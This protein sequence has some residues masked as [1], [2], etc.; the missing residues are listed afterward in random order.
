M[1][2]YPV[3]DGLETAGLTLWSATVADY[4]LTPA[5]IRILEDAAREADLIAH[6]DREW[7]R[8]GR[9]LISLGSAKQEVA[10]PILMELRQHRGT[11][12]QLLNNL[13]LPSATDSPPSVI[14]LVDELGNPR[15]MTRSESG[16]YAASVRY[17]RAG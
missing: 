7:I 13:R 10:H 6:L 11:L 2:D 3:P 4:E 14:P 8:L 5:E 1:T 16:R 15:K 12:R 9:P 17:G